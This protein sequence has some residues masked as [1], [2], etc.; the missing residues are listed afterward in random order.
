MLPEKCTYQVLNRIQVLN[1]KHFQLLDG[2]LHIIVE[3]DPHGCE[4][5]RTKKT[6][7]VKY[8]IGG[9]LTVLEDQDMFTVAGSMVTGRQRLGL[10]WA[11]CT[12]NI[13]R[14]LSYIV[15]G[16]F[17]KSEDQVLLSLHIL[18][19]LQTFC[20][21]F[22]LDNPWTFL[23]YDKLLLKPQT[24]ICSS[25]TPIWHVLVNVVK[26]ESCASKF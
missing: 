22:K 14:F 2:S 7:K 17:L 26:N 12:L 10:Q 19:C 15:S 13:Y 8:L 3:N 6:H 5:T 16:K 20:F 1:A 9:V 21:S 23:I 25:W 11:L 18:Q 24:Q 4:E